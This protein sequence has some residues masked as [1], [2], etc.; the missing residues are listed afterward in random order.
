VPVLQGMTGN[1]RWL[2]NRCYHQVFVSTPQTK[3][4]SLTISHG[5]SWTLALKYTQSLRST[6]TN[7]SPGISLV[8]TIPHVHFIKRNPESTS[9][10]SQ[11][12]ESNLVCFLRSFDMIEAN[13]LKS[14]V[15]VKVRSFAAP[16]G[17][18]IVFRTRD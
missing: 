9:L 12:I 4:L 11:S 13:A 7:A 15:D 3:S 16:V 14:S 8:R 18:V 6:L 5:S 17:V 1:Q 10:E 2:T